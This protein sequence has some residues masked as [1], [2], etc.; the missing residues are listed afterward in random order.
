MLLTWY[1]INSTRP[2][3]LTRF[4]ARHARAA[5]STDSALWKSS[6]VATVQTVCELHFG[7]YKTIGCGWQNFS[8]TSE[9]PLPWVVLFQTSTS[10]VCAWKVRHGA[11]LNNRIARD[12]DARRVACRCCVFRF[13]PQI[14]AVWQVWQWRRHG[15]LSRQKHYVTKR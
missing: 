7:H 14:Q 5:G 8:R 11:I 4:P 3:R 9:H 15:S 1:K 12:L 2:R 13:M 10:L 6:F